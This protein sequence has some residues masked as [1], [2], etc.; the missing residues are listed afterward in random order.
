MDIEKEIVDVA[1]DQYEYIIDSVCKTLGIDI[2]DRFSCKYGSVQSKKIRIL[3]RVTFHKNIEI[4][5]LFDKRIVSGLSIHMYSDG[6]LMIGSKVDYAVKCT[7]SN[8]LYFGAFKLQ[9]KLVK[10]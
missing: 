3:D 10:R 7:I 9:C 1:K 8:I 2:S 4:Q 6:S 5:I